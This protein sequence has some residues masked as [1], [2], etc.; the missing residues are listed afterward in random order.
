MNPERS[1]CARSQGLRNDE[2]TTK[3][4]V[5]A[6]SLANP[7]PTKKR[8]ASLQPAKPSHWWRSAAIY[9]VYIRSFA[10]GNGDGIKDP[11]NIDDAALAAARYLCAAST[12]N[13]PAAWRAAVQSYNN[14]TPYID[15]IA[16]AANRYAVEASGR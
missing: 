15:M 10:D 13:T 7:V 12:M 1:D 8:A 5:T 6:L 2:P 4:E 14:S 3:G 16:T 11:Q 9:Q